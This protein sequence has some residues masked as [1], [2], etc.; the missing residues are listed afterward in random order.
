MPRL[1]VDADRNLVHETSTEVV[2]KYLAGLNIGYVPDFHNANFCLSDN[3]RELV[4]KYGYCKLINQS[5]KIHFMKERA[6]DY[7]GEKSLKL[8][9][10]QLCKL[11][12]YWG[13]CA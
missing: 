12:L 3:L 11:Q 10:T 7:L 1:V 2:L 8:Y 5:L 13:D 6:C 9:I 4:K